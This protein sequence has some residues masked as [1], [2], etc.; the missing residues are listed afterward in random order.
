MNSRICRVLPQDRV[1]SRAPHTSKD[2]S[3]FSHGTAAVSVLFGVMY[4]LGDIG[5]EE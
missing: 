3:R 4:C 5:Y 1:Q 2:Y